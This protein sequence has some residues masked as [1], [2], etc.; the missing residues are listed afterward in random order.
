[1]ISRYIVAND[2]SADG[3]LAVS[4]TLKDRT[5]QIGILNP[6]NGSYVQLTSVDW[7]LPAG[8]FFSPDGKYLGG[9]PAVER[10]DGKPRP[11]SHRRRRY[12]SN[13]RGEQPRLR[14]PCRL[15]A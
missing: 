13:T 14:R 9:R 11:P 5:G 1:M 2:W 15:D 8:M 3:R 6:A 7:R 12:A 10:D 4:I